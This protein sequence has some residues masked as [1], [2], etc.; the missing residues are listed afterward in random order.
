MDKTI[1][2]KMD[3]IFTG[4]GQTQFKAYDYLMKESEKPV[5][6]AYDVW[7]EVV[8]GL[9]HKDNHV[10][11]ICGQLLGN[12]GK[13]DPKGR[14]FKDFDKLLNVTKDEKFVTARHT[15]QNIWK[16]GLGGKKHQQLVVQGLE[17]RFKECIKEKNGAL[18]RYDI[19]VT[20]RNL[21]NATTS[22][23]I[24]EKALE[25]IELEQDAKYKKKYATVWKKA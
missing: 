25:L 19:L 4:D 9:T 21:Y 20:L 16:V 23:E 11:A 3:D 15:M 10:R 1:R 14:M 8:S 7:D 2:S 12:L 5:S 6:W 18:I 17:K 13:S 24:K 22:N